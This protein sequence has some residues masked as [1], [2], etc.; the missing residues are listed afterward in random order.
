MRLL[1]YMLVNISKPSFL[2]PPVGEK[3]LLPPGGRPGRGNRDLHIK[4]KF[5]INVAGNNRVLFQ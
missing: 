2:F 4:A 5:V 3:N 1:M